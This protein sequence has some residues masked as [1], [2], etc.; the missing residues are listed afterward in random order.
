MRSMQ[1]YPFASP[2]P[3]SSPHTHTRPS[4]LDSFA[5]LSAHTST[6]MKQLTSD[7]M[8]PLHT[9]VLL[10]LQVSGDKDPELEVNGQ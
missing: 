6:L 7:K 4:V 2:S 1:L 9:R 5:S 8:P 10:P 3:F